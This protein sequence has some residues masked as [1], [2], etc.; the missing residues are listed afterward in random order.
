MGVRPLAISP[1]SLAPSDKAAR[2]PIFQPLEPSSTEPH[3]PHPGRKRSEPGRPARIN[4]RAPTIPASTTTTSAPTMLPPSA[5]H[6]QGASGAKLG[7]ERAFS[8]IVV[9]AAGDRFLPSTS[10]GCRFIPF[11]IS[12]P[13]EFGALLRRA[14]ILCGIVLPRCRRGSE[15][16]LARPQDVSEGRDDLVEISG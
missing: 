15:V 1:K 6:R 5:R 9:V 16:W 10:R 14:R 12:L 7:R 2:V 11:A 13:Q 8:C 3:P 4:A